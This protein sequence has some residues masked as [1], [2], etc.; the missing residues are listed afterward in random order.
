MRTLVIDCS[1]EACSGA[2][3][4]ET[5]LIAGFHEMLGRGHAERLVP[6]IASL[7]NKGQAERIVVALGPGS[8]T[9]VRVGIATARALAFAWQARLAGYSTSA[10]IAAMARA[11]VGEQDVAVAMAGGHGEWFVEGFAPDGLV[12]RP[13]TSLLPEVAATQSNEHVVAGTRAQELV[14]MRG[15]GHALTLWP[16]ARAFSQ[17]P[18]VA[19]RDNVEPIYG[20]GPDAK[21]PAA[22]ACPK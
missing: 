6:M 7:P 4:D 11:E 15:S 9:G 8:F 3:F 20:R 21:L 10:L 13:L 14:T 19:L 16:D 22:P 17:L 12:R 1:T 2:L 18:D 5:D